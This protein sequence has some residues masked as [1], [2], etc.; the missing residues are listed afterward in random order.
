M[1][2]SL[3]KRRV[4][5]DTLPFTKV[6]IPGGFSVE[7]VHACPEIYSEGQSPDSIVA[8]AAR[9]SF[10]NYKQINDEKSDARLI[11]YLLRNRHT[12]PFEMATLTFLIKAPKFVTIQLLRHRTFRFNEESQ[13]YHQITEGFFHP[14]SDP[15]HFIRAQHKENKQSST[16]DENISAKLVDKFTKIENK[17]DEIFDLYNEVIDMGAA[18]ECARFCLPMSTWSHIVVQCDMNNLTKFL[19]LRLANDAQ[20]EIR[21]I[22]QAMYILAQK[23]F[24][25]I[26]TSFDRHMFKPETMGFNTDN[27]KYTSTSRFSNNQN[28]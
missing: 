5:W 7:L 28:E 15:K 27:F 22:A 24:P 3:P 6:D 11:D 2:K 14:S 4:L 26:I 10:N 21:L 25:I 18:R 8:A 17:L 16:I 1:A 13:R 12:S 23:V 19:T 9:T 20:Y